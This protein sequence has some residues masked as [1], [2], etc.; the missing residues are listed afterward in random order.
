[1]NFGI[2]G[3]AVNNINCA[4]PAS[5]WMVPLI[6]D[7][8]CMHALEF[9]TEKVEWNVGGVNLCVYLPTLVPRAK[10]GGFAPAKKLHD[11][12]FYAILKRGLV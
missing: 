5:A 4:V 11:G 7:A 12:E 8:E 6:P 9:Q 1:M 2:D 3:T 10:T